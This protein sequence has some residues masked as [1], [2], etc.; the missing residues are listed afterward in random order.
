MR[1][2]KGHVRKHTGFT[3]V[4]LVVVV[5]I[6]G[7]LAA[8]AAPKLLAT[9][10]TATDNGLKQTLGIV[11]DAIERYAAE[12]NGNLPPA[13]TEAAFK[14]ALKPYLRGNFPVCPIGS[15]AAVAIVSD[16]PLAVTGTTGGWIFSTGSGE[17]AVNSTAP[18]NEGT[19]YNMF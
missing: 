19:A 18:S 9:S 13:G 14:L 16:D 11:R 12:N 6:L 15:S 7:I 17:F 8:V 4:E 3:L 1:K 5:M 2:H 10:G